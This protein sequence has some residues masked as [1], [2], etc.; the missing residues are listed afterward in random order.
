ME[1]RH[2]RYFVAVA[3]A[4]SFTEA[5]R[6]LALSQPPLSMQIRDLESEIGTELIT[7]S[8][9]RL[10]LTG[11]GAAFLAKAKLILA[12]SEQAIAEARAIG[13]GRVGT[14]DIGLTG[15]VLLGGLGALVA[16]Y[17]VA[18]PSVL[19]RLHEM[20]PDEQ[21]SA[22][23]AG[24]LDLCFLRGPRPQTGLVAEPAWAEGVCVALPRGHGLAARRRLR[25]TGLRDEAFV[26]FRRSNSRFAEHLWTCCIEAGFA[27]RII[28]EAVE[29]S[30]IMALVADGF[31]L[32]L[33]PE[34]AQRLAPADIVFRPLSDS[35]AQADV[36]LI[37]RQEPPPVVSNFIGFA[38]A[39]LA[40]R[41]GSY[42]ARAEPCSRPG[43][44]R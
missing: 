21:E 33:L 44:G 42:P 2:L 6:R 37:Y 20:P 30:A 1:L 12:E 40:Q 43:R 31:G 10:A 22:L 9:R 39:R 32:A 7:R 38:R 5:A 3:E 17:Q 28:Q 35:A 26:F 27:P 34:T 16:A 14:L 15:A 36:S 23:A 41:R 18:F 29:A 11:A 4:L 13:S 24:R 8:S 19:V 25:L